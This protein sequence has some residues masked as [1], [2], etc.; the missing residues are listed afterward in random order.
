M[1]SSIAGRATITTVV[2]RNASAEPSAVANSVSSL[3]RRAESNA[4]GADSAGFIGH[5]T[6]RAVVDM[7]SSLRA[8]L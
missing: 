5:A 3:T 4:S 2:S 7:H 8:I 1:S 6:G